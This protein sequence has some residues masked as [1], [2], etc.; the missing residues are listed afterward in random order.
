MQHVVIWR[1][2]YVEVV[3]HG[4][5]NVPGMAAM[6]AGLL[7]DTRWEPGGAILVNHTDLNAA[8]LTVAHVQAIADM[9]SQ[10]RKQ[11]G[12]ARVAHVV[13]RDLEFGLVRMWEALIDGHWDASA[14]CFRSY[15]EAVA[16]LK[17]GRETGK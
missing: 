2:G 5:A 3:T 1:E 6:I 9:G 8:P 10:A 4:D 16:W 14:M 7:T 12:K 11:V 13:S 17:R 15:D